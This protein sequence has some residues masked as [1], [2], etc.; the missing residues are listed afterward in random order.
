MNTSRFVFI[1]YIMS[2]LFC[3]SL[4]NSDDIQLSSKG[5][6]LLSSKVDL[7]TGEDIE[8]YNYKF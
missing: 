8:T 4:K 2:I 3:I 5:S 1:M 6:R 7:V